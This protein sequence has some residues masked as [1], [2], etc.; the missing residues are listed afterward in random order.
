MVGDDVSTRD[1]KTH[2]LVR[3]SARAAIDAAPPSLI[4][5]VIE[6]RWR[7]VSEAQIAHFAARL[8]AAC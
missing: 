1:G 3:L 4:D 2:S 8:P 7:S 5:I 6:P